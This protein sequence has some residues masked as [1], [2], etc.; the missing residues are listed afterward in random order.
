MKPLPTPT[1]FRKPP[2]RPTAVSHGVQSKTSD[3]G[4]TA[5]GRQLAGRLSELVA[6]AARELG[7]DARSADQVG[8]EGT[9]RIGEHTVSILPVVGADGS[10]PTLLLCIDADEAFDAANPKRFAQLAGH[11]SG[12]LAVFSVSIGVSPASRW[13][14]YR[15]L[16]LAALNPGRLADALA[17]SV[18]LIDVVFG[19]ADGADQ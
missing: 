3:S 4:L 12:L 17:A 6:G 2:P 13:T 19:N 18:Q 7:L 15:S 11:A 16:E 5:E 10:D 9:I 14:L 1:G 8:R